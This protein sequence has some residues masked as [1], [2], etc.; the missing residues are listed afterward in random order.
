MT[1]SLN[2][3][4][5]T[6]QKRKVFRQQNNNDSKDTMKLNSDLLSETRLV[7]NNELSPGLQEVKITNPT[8]TF[9]Q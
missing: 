1:T 6:P 3:L 2:C 4:T 8:P 5:V 9:H 7:Q